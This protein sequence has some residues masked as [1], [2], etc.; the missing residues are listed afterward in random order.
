MQILTKYKGGSLGNAPA[1]DALLSPK[2]AVEVRREFITESAITTHTYTLTNAT[3]TRSTTLG[4]GV[5][6]LSQA[7]AAVYALTSVGAVAQTLA[8]RTITYETSASMTDVTTASIAMFVGLG[9]SSTLSPITVAGAADG[10]RSCI[11]FSFAAGTI[12]GVIGNGAT[13]TSVAL[14]TGN[15]AGTLRR[16][17]FVVKGAGTVDWYVD[18]QFVSTSSATLPTVVLYEQYATAATTATGVAIDYTYIAYTR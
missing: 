13:V 12:N 9:S 10:T 5:W 2:D 8:G 6:T 15:T 16:L 14:A 17:G 4:T 1:V 3:V 7:S 18:G 11:G